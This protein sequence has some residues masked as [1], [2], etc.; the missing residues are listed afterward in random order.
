LGIGGF[1]VISDAPSAGGPNLNA[2]SGISFRPFTL[3]ANWDN[4]DEMTSLFPVIAV[5]YVYEQMTSLPEVGHRLPSRA[6]FLSRASVPRGH[7]ENGLV[8]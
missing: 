1:F 3:P 2:T 7:I 6:S 4:T 5:M 8:S